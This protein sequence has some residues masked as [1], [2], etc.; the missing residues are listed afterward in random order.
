MEQFSERQ[1]LFEQM[2]AELRRYNEDLRRGR[3]PEEPV[4]APEVFLEF[5]EWQAERL[6]RQ[7]LE[8]GLLDRPPMQLPRLRR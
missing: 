6:G 8:Q 2:E 4:Y 3:S 1:R 5:R 7:A